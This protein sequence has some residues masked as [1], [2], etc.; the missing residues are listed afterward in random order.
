MANLET[1]T[2]E[3]VSEA[4]Q[5]IFDQL[6][7]AVG[8]VPNLYTAY[9]HA[10]TALADYLTLSNRKTSLNN[11]EKEVVNLIVSETNNCDYCKAAHTAVSKM[12]GFTDEQ[13]LEIRSGSAH[14]D[15]KLDALAQ[16]VQNAAI[17]KGQADQAPIDAFFAAGYTKE[18]LVDVV[19]LIGD[20]TISNYLFGLGKFAI[21][22]P[23]AQELQ[24][25]SA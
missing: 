11:K 16:L 8:F 19:L 3:Q 4:N 24:A 22:F 7:S 10:E 23:A 5:Q 21:D 9:T 17:N 6:K 1:K 15:S 18:N 13:I 14:F 20:K 25:V 12:N 2:R